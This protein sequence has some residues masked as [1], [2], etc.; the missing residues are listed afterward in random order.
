MA[1][2]QGNGDRPRILNPHVMDL[3][4][5]GGMKAQ[6]LR[7]EIAIPVDQEQK[8]RKTLME[9]TAL[10]RELNSQL[11]QIMGTLDAMEKKRDAVSPIESPGHD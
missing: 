4:N 8:V 7:M 11:N 6:P 3:R 1:N 10:A 2:G 5:A 9:L